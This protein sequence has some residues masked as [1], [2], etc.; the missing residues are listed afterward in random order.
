MFK[1]HLL[2]SQGS[3]GS[4]WAFVAVE[5]IESYAALSNVSHVELSVEEVNT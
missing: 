5:Q 2:F 3:C 4:C 1:N